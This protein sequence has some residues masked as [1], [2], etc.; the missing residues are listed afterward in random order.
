[1]NLEDLLDEHKEVSTK[2]LFQSNLET[3]STIALQIMAG[4]VLKEHISK[5]PALLLCVKGKVV[6]QDEKDNETVLNPG[7]YKEIVPM[8][9]HRVKGISD[10]Q[11]ILCK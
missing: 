6:Y 9:K 3:S 2:M 11:L 7:Q 4:G 1:M 5:T 10:S 8:V